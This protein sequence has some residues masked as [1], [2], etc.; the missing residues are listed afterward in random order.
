RRMVDHAMSELSIDGIADKQINEL[1]GGQL[2]MVSIAQALVK[3]P[4]LLLM[5]EPTNNL[6]LQKQLEMFEVVR[7]L[8]EQR[9]LVTVMILHDLNLAARF[10]DEIVV[11]QDGRVYVKGPAG[12][13][14][15]GEMLRDVY[16]VDAEVVRD[17]DGLPHVVAYGSLKRVRSWW[18]WNHIEHGL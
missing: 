17:R 18:K 9:G 13:V 16:K 11:L 15:T 12:D 4:Q 1:S 8:S 3:E 7:E 5:D 2:Q 10:A 6:D 14:F